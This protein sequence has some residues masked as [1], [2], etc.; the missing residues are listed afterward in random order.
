MARPLVEELFFCAFP[1]IIGK[2]LFS[3]L[4][5]TYKVE[6]VIVKN[7][8]PYV[9]ALLW[10][11]LNIPS[12]DGILTSLCPFHKTLPRSSAFINW[13]SIRFYETIHF[14]L[15]KYYGFQGKKSL[16]FSQGCT[17]IQNKNLNQCQK[18]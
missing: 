6:C 13:I 14:K 17:Y 7:Y 16:Y 4:F 2:L 3:Y 18:N 12:N 15:L 1:Y 8:T 5:C 9:T 11:Q 10:A